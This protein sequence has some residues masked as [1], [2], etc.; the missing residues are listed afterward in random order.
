MKVDIYQTNKSGTFLFLLPG[1]PFSS[2]PRPVLDTVGLLQFLD[3]VEIDL[4]T[5]GMT[6]SDILDDIG[7]QG[8]SLHEATFKILDPG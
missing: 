6:H 4:E 1:E 2:V 7:K 5:L 8:Y 3:T